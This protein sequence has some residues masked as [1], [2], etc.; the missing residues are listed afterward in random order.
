M[1]TPYLV[2]LGSVDNPGDAKTGA[3]IAHWRRE[4]CIGQHRMPGCEVD[5]GLQDLSIDEAVAAGAKTLIVGIAPD[6]GRF[7]ATW[8]PA[9]VEAL[10]KG[11]DVA[12]GLHERLVD[13]PEVRDMAKARGR[14]LFDVRQPHRSFPVGTGAKRP[15]LRL[16]TVGTDCAVGKMY[17]SLAVEREMRRRGMK[18]DF[19][20]TGQTGILIAGQG[21]SVDAVV[22]DFVAG[23]SE[24]LSPANEADHWDVIEG[25]GSLF[26]PSYAAVTLGLVHGSQPDAMVLCHEAGRTQIQNIEGYPIPELGTCMEIYT[27][28]A[29]LTNPAATFVGICINTSALDEETALKYVRET[30][31]AQRLPCCDPVRHGVGAIVDVLQSRR[32]N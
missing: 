28:A 10:D 23:A 21:V 3:G 25:Q 30:G 32:W 1:Q 4:L 31:Q 17:T 16:L 15:G 6:G 8:T 12:A 18:A 11:L 5:L 26:H 20:A 14:A 24:G 9:L 27:S 19:R 22:S 2:F 13:I 7:C 29:R